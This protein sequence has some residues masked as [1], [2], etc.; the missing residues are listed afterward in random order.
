MDKTIKNW[1]TKIEGE[2]F[3]YK[4]LKKGCKL[5]L[6]EP[7]AWNKAFFPLEDG[8]TDEEAEW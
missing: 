4:N 5:M 7:L 8:L 3:K 2:L 6:N 1:E